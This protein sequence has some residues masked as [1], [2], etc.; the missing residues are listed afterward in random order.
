MTAVEDV[1]RAY[2]P[3]IV[4]A[5]RSRGAGRHPDVPMIRCR[6]LAPGEAVDRYVVEAVIGQGGMAAVYRVR[7]ATLGTRHA[8]K[9]L[10]IPGESLRAR[11][12]QEGRIQA[13]LRHPNVIAVTDVFQA[14]GAPALL[15]DYVDGPNLQDWIT[16]HRPLTIAEAERIFRGLLDG[17][18]H[19]HAAGVIHRD[20]KPA[21][22][23]LADPS[24]MRIPRITDFGI[25]KIVQDQVGSFGRTAAGSTFGS[26]GYMAPEQVESTRDVDSRCDIFSL[27]CI[28]YELLGG[29]PVFQRDSV[30]ATLSAMAVNA[31]TPVEAVRPDVPARLAL[32]VQ[33]CLVRDRE[34]R[35]PDCATV[36]AILD[37]TVSEWRADRP[38][39]R[40]APAS[41]NPFEMQAASNETIVIDAEAGP[42][43]IG[44]GAAEQLDT[45]GGATMTP[46]GEAGVSAGVAAGPPGVARSA[47]PLSGPAQGVDVWATMK[48]PAPAAAPASARA[49]V[50]RVAIVAVLGLTVAGSLRWFPHEPKPTPTAGAPAPA[51]APTSPVS[52]DPLGDSNAPALPTVTK[53]SPDPASAPSSAAAP[54]S[55]PNSPKKK[56]PAPSSP[57]N[58]WWTGK[59]GDAPPPEAAETHVAKAPRA[60]GRLKLSSVPFGHV[61]V[62]GVSGGSGWYN[63]EVPA[64]P[65]AIVLTT[66]AGARHS[67]TIEVVPGK[68]V[69][70]CWDFDLQV[71][72]R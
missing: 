66:D 56:N 16:E 53:A 12:I 28:L 13:T 43:R 4:R 11:L 2:L 14:G 60:T 22:V 47:D 42:A 69:N 51:D 30:M 33:A 34:E 49:L 10:T 59:A 9:Q 21:N 63:K 27:G 61:T 36:R 67:K 44:T 24:R 46:V 68:T 52:P 15:M 37:G 62:D 70:Y 18:E 45:E 1:A 35:A 17:M 25:A 54:V 26:P 65:H 72:C 3:K 31:W 23:L 7:H 50:V 32:A 41:N 57:T 19:A 6:M 39:R 71:E 38:V 29:R 48:P 8:L 5:E 58:G 20:L 55:A 64:G 40:V